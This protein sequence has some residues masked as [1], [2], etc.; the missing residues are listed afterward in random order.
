VDNNS[1]LLQ[2]LKGID[3]A[4]GE[5]LGHKEHMYKFRDVS[6]AK[7]AQD[8]GCLGIHVERPDDIV[9]ALKEAL[10]SNRPAVVDVVTNPE[11]HPP[12]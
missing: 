2:G 10:A 7:I 5:N 9:P 4:Y 3:Q 11:C 12:D 8:I 1:G 6:F